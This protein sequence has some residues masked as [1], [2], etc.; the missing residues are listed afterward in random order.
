MAVWDKRHHSLVKRIS[1]K[2]PHEHESARALSVAVSGGYIYVGS[3][4]CKIRVFDMRKYEHVTTLT[5]HNWEVWQLGYSEG[6]LFSGSFDH[7]VRVWEEKTWTCVKTLAGHNGYIHA[8][9]IDKG[10]LFTGSGDKSIKL[11]RS[12]DL[13]SN[14]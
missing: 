13:Y 9:A 12:D 3:D 2:E 7:T 1:N 14:Y 4:D 11:W 6:Y 8:L 10:T 5:G